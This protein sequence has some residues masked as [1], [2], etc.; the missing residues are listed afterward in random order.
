MPENSPLLFFGSLF[1]F[2]GVRFTEINR[3]GIDAIAQTGW[4]WSIWKYVPKVCITLAAYDFGTKHAQGF[5]LMLGNDF[6]VNR[7]EIAWP[8]A[9]GIKLGV[10]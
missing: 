2:P 6:I 10:G 3:G 5:V 4:G 1:C 9:P 7:L 8:A